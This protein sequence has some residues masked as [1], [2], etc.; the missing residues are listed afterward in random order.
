MVTKAPCSLSLRSILILF[1]PS[2][3]RCESGH[4]GWYND[5]LQAE[6]PGFNSQLGLRLHSMQTGSGTHPASYPRVKWL[7]LIST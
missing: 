7:P 3:D 5:R 1:F 4:L 6:R 2:N